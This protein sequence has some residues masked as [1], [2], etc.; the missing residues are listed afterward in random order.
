MEQKHNPYLD[1]WVTFR[2]FFI[3]KMMLVKYSYAF[4]AMP[5]GFGT[6]DE[7]FECLTL[8]QTGK[9]KDF[10]MVFMGKD[11]WEPL[12]GF[13]KDTLLKEQ[14]I[15]KDDFDKLIVSD[16]PE[17]VVEKIRDVAMKRFGVSYGKKYKPRWYL[18][19]WG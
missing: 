13:I 9:I 1:K 14:T 18:G 6:M 7:V 5:G 4:I 15:D 16:S 12:L 11:Y 2:Y 8:I 10:P 3:R 19:E 17:E